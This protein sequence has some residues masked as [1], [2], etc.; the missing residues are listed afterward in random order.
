MIDDHHIEIVDSYHHFWDLDKKIRENGTVGSLSSSGNVY[1]SGE[2]HGDKRWHLEEF[3]KRHYRNYDRAYAGIYHNESDI[4]I[5]KYLKK[6]IYYAKGFKGYVNRWGADDPDIQR[7]LGFL[8]RFLIVF[9]EHGKWKKL[10]GNPTLAFGMYGLRF[11]VGFAYF[12][13]RLSDKI[14]LK[15]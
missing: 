2:N 6:K 14:S 9:L 10:I 11:L 4:E 15:R 1:K 12:W 13:H 7:Q 3:I 8:Y 5:S